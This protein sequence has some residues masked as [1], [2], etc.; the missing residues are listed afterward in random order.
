MQIYQNKKRLQHRFF[1]IS[2]EIFK[3]TYFEE[4]LR[5]TAPKLLFR[6]KPHRL[7]KMRFLDIAKAYFKTRK[8]GTRN[9]GTRNTG[10][11][12]EHWRTLAEP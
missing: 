7:N 3:N 10:R 2:C 1:F 8:A 12:G 11:I 4:H 5:T 6:E 9:N